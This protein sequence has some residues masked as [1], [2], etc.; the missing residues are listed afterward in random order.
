MSASLAL[1]KKP[2][3]SERLSGAHKK[4]MI[5]IKDI[6]FAYDK[7]E[8]LHNINLTI[9]DGSFSVIVGPNGGGKTTLLKLV[10]GILTP[11]YG[12]ITIDGL[13]PEKTRSKIAYVPQNI[14]ADKMLPISVMDTV[15]MGRLP[16]GWF[17]KY[18]ADDKKSALEALKQVGL[19]GFEKRPFNAL[20]GGERQRVLIA[21]ALVSKATMLLLDEPGASLDPDH[22]LQLYELLETLK[23]S[24]EITILLVSH[25]LNV[26]ASYASHIIC[27]NR[28]ADS[29]RIEEVSTHALV[30]GAWT[31]LLH[32]DC[33][34][35]N[36]DKAGQHTPH[37]G[38]HH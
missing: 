17:S 25:N 21:Q 28:T 26:V 14:N 3:L 38:C 27:V 5:Q 2:N 20:S 35:S 31:Q 13:P 33:P 15:L 19:E 29:H 7:T 11:M 4:T 30:H 12:T 24:H 23:Q 32:N 22:R 37:H 10:L 1:T 8:V 16:T 34:V 36:E 18:S 6:C 9:E